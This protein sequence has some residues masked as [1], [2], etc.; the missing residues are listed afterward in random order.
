MEKCRKSSI[1]IEFESGMVRIQ[2]DLEI[3]KSRN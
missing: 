2:W 3:M 1:D